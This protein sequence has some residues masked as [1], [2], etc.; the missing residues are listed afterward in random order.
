MTIA[1]F[2]GLG[3]VAL[4]TLPHQTPS[5]AGAPV[6]T[7][8][9]APAPSQTDAASQGDAVRSYDDD[10]GGRSD[11]E[12]EDRYEHDERAERID[13]ARLRLEYEHDD[14]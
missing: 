14:D 13:E 8:I 2:G 5:A 3:A 6:T 11:H 9:A 7:T 12:H 1:A 4:S 10:H